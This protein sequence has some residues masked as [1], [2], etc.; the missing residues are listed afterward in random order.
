LKSPKVINNIISNNSNTVI[1]LNVLSGVI[2]QS[3]DSLH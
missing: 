3:Q 2:V 1:V